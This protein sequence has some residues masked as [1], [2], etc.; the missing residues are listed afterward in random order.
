[1]LTNSWFYFVERVSTLLPRQLTQQ[2]TCTKSKVREYP[3]GDYIIRCTRKNKIFSFTTFS[4]VIFQ[5]CIE[6][7][8]GYETTEGNILY[9]HLKVK[10]L[11]RLVGKCIRGKF[12]RYNLVSEFACR[13]IT[14]TNFHTYRSICNTAVGT[15]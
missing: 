7:P 15:H 10:K 2:Y 11:R 8:L 3:P 1:M 9:V 5:H 12:A 14:H 13:N 6:K 4:V